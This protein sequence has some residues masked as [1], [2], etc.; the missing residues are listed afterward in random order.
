M[1]QNNNSAEIHQQQTEE[2]ADH[3]HVQDNNLTMTGKEIKC[4]YSS[5]RLHV[6]NHHYHHITICIVL[7][8]T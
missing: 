1:T 4:K 7:I 8:T 5:H 6:T 3:C 2:P